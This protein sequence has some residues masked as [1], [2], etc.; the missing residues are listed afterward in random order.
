[1]LAVGWWWWAGRGR[2]GGGVQGW[3]WRAGTVAVFR[4]GD[5]GE[6]ECRENGKFGCDF[7]KM[8]GEAESEGKEH[9]RRRGESDLQASKNIIA[10]GEKVTCKHQRT[11]SQEGRK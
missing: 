4:V 10:G 3:G 5:G 2:D 6:Y 11:S 7:S 9:H 1:M 8:H